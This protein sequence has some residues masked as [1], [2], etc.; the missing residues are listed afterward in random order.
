MSTEPIEDTAT[1]TAPGRR[2]GRMAWFYVAACAV[3]VLAVLG[4][5]AWNSWR[6]W[7]FDAAEAARRQHQTA[8]QLGLPVEKSVD[9]G[10]GIAIELVLIPAGMFE[11]GSPEGEADR[12]DEEGPL[13][14]V[15]ISRP[16]YMG[17]YEVTQEVWEKVTGANPSNFKGAKRPVE[18]VSWDDCQGFL[19]KLNALVKGP[20]RFRLPTEAEWEW[21]CR[22][23][24]RTRFC[25]GDADAGLDAYAWYGGNPGR[26]PH[27]VSTKQ[28]NAWGLHDCHG[29]VW[30]WCADRHGAYG[31]RR[32]VFSWETDP[33]GPAAGS[34]RV[35][36]GGA[37]GNI[38]GCRSAARG[39]GPPSR[40]G[41][42]GL[43]VL[44]VVPSPGPQ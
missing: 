35:A 31:P 1:P 6:H 16:F 32:G 43:R 34:A 8:G 29:N 42:I 12:N 10:G 36:R 22:A 20:G 5:W 41:S 18:T 4:A 17:K 33:G 21:A 3:V 25:S 11:M 37:W 40:R 23:G 28:P 19:K 9:L 38:G 2:R 15:R 13:R 14:W 7:W 27:P 44:E 30:E 39:Y 24:T 26:A